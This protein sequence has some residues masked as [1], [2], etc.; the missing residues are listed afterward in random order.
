M[1]RFLLDSSVSS[2][3][4]FLGN[5]LRSILDEED[6]SS[7]IR[8]TPND[9]PSI[10]V[11]SEIQALVVTQVMHILNFVV[12]NSA[13]PFR[14]Q[15]NITFSALNFHHDQPVELFVRGVL[16]DLFHQNRILFESDDN[17][18]SYCFVDFFL[19]L[20]LPTPSLCLPASSA[21]PRFPESDF[22][23][24]LSEEQGHLEKSAKQRFHTL[25]E[26]RTIQC[27]RVWFLRSQRYCHGLDR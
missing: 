13:S 8:C 22:L 10:I 26:H 18:S 23:C 3:L 20:T 12:L 1:L 2:N 21:C 15:S 27:C 19:T 5:F 9:L 6:F 24:F 14:T 7:P 4:E 16:G 11:V 25:W 17:D